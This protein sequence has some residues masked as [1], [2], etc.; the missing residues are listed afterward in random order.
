MDSI[1][2]KEWLGIYKSAIKE[3]SL[4]GYREGGVSDYISDVII[5]AAKYTADKSL[6]NIRIS[7][8]KDWLDI[9]KS[10]IIKLIRDVNLENQYGE[11]EIDKIISIAKKSADK[12]LDII[13]INKPTC[14]NL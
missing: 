9:Y 6:E 1:E 3:F 8:D 11:S 2:Y 13:K 4:I 5:N 12:S 14:F 10:I 7:S